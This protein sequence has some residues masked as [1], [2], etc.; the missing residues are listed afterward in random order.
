MGAPYVSITS[1]KA[2]PKLSIIDFL[3]F[4]S[5][6]INASDSIFIESVFAIPVMDVCILKLLLLSIILTFPS[7]ERFLSFGL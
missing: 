7:K 3:I 6:T 4:T 2:R 1:T 5:K